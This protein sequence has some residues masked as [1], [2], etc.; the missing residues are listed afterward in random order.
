MTWGFVCFS[1]AIFYKG[2][3]LGYR[4]INAWYMSGDQKRAPEDLEVAA[5]HESGHVI[6]AWF[7]PDVLSVDKVTIVR[8][9]TSGGKTTFAFPATK[10]IDKTRLMTTIA[11]ALAGRV[12]E[13]CNGLEPS[14][15][16][17]NDI[18]I[19]TR[20]AEQMVEEHSMSPSLPLRDMDRT[21]GPALQD[22]IDAAIEEILTIATAS[23]KGLLEPRK[24]ALKRLKDELLAKR[25]L[26]TK[27]IEAILGPRPS[28]PA[29][30]PPKP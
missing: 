6:A 15:G 19:A 18:E 9:G 7:S 13:E 10:V 11:I 1:I 21:V 26:D 17:K 30:Q 5:A 24:E 28:Q 22:R 23:A 29:T 12:A 25:T 2:V 27:D 16:A 4:E 20:I 14:T 3:S 8:K